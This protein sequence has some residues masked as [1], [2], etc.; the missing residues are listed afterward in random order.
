MK[1]ADRNEMD[2]LLRAHA[3]RNADSLHAK[4]N[5][6]DGQSEH[7]DADELNAFA[8]GV[9]PERARTRYS[10]HLAECANCRSVVIKLTQAAGFPTQLDQS[11]ERSTATFW[12]RMTGMFSQPV[13]RFVIPAIV[14]V[15][16]LGIGL[17]ALRQN[18]PSDFV[19]QHQPAGPQPTVSQVNQSVQLPSPSEAVPLTKNASTPPANVGAAPP[20]FNAPKGESG[21]SGAGAVV[22]S[23]PELLRKDADTAP[24]ENTVVSPQ[25]RNEPA[26]PTPLPGFAAGRARPQPSA[27]DDVRKGEAQ[28][29]QADEMK[30]QTGAV[31][32]ERDS[33]LSAKSAASPAKP[34]SVRGMM[35]ERR[36]TRS[37]DKESTESTE[38]RTVSGKRFVR[39]NEAWVDIAYHSGAIT[40]VRRGSEQ[41]RALVADE[42]NIRT[43]AEQLSGEVIVVWKGRA[44][45]IR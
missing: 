37:K 3:R 2:V 17:I 13:L 14:L 39:Q 29:S 8:E 5:G 31:A 42:P 26:A 21:S 28:Q 40:S 15:S 18:E 44:Y 34:D 25:V 9:L 4:F 19:A 33:A 22:S 16:I 27:K 36:A 6:G 24:S 20:T 23:G 35:T 11:E 41:Y 45:R 12:Q 10:E 43:F 7:L 32:A 38:T 1:H 30:V